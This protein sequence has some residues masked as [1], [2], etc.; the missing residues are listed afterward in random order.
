[1]LSTVCEIAR[2]SLYIGTTTVTWGSNV[3]G[4]T[5]KLFGRTPRRKFPKMYRLKK[6][7]NTNTDAV[8]M[9]KNSLRP[10]LVAGKSAACRMGNEL[11][12]ESCVIRTQS[13]RS[14]KVRNII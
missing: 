2:P 3:E 8:S 10:I 1:M 9:S 12:V 6:T 7:R 4:G 11:E 14:I 13:Y 5:L